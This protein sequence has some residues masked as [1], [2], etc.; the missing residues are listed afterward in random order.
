MNL[1]IENISRLLPVVPL[2]DYGPTSSCK[3]ITM[4]QNR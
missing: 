4:L 2:D 3:P 1:E